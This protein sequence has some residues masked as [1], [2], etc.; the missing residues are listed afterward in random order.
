ML[1]FLDY[2]TLLWMRAQQGQAQPPTCF[3]GLLPRLQTPAGTHFTQL[4]QT[5]T[6]LGRNL[7]RVGSSPESGASGWSKREIHFAEL[8]S[9]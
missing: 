2:T 1:R 9:R 5:F 3:L 7:S 4:G 6:G 8:L